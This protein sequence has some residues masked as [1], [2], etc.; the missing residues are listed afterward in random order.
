MNST[1]STA[2]CLAGISALAF[3]DNPFNKSPRFEFAPHVMQKNPKD[4]SGM[5]HE[6]CSRSVDRLLLENFDF[7]G[8]LEENTGTWTDSTFSGWERIFWKD[9]R[10]TDQSLDES[11]RKTDT[12]WKRIKDVFNDGS[13]SMWGA[14]GISFEDPTQGYL[15]DCWF[16]AASSVVSQVPSRIKKVFHTEALNSA[17]VYAVDLHMMGIP[18]TVTVDDYLPFWKDAWGGKKL[19]YG[20]VGKDGA[21]W[22]PIL[23]KAGAKLFGSYEHLVSGSMGPA[24][25]TLTGAPY[26]SFKH[27][28]YSVDGL[29]DFINERFN[30][31]WMVTCGSF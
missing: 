31:N 12:E 5:T 15:G 27:G 26:F 14:T 21:L 3:A 4:G 29:W 9:Y 20:Q 23:E 18:V 17:G 13:N 28:D 7:N 24:I 1:F 25:Q 22:M 10:P 11:A 8:P 16:I 19:V 6:I 2:L 30:S